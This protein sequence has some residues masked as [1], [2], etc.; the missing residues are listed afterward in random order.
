MAWFLTWVG[1][2]IALGAMTALIVRVPAFRA[3][4]AARAAAWAVALAVIA[5]LAVVPLLPPATASQVILTTPAPSSAL[6]RAVNPVVIPAVPASWLLWGLAV[7]ACGAVAWLAHASLE[8]HRVVVLKRA[9]IP[10]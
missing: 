4:A 6:D 9:C 1:H 7:W 3:R 8:I 10:M 2:S 5:L